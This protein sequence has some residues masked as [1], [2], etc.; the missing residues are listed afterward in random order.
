MQETAIATQV[1]SMTR[2]MLQEIERHLDGKSLSES[3][4]YL[5]EIAHSMGW[6]WVAFN[7]DTSSFVLPTDERGEYL[8][9][10]MGWSGSYLSEWEARRLAQ[11]CPVAEACRQTLLPF[12]WDMDGSDAWS[13]DAL[14]DLQRQALSYYR[15]YAEGGVTVPVHRPEGKTAYISW[16][17]GTRQQARR[18]YDE[19]ADFLFLVSHCYVQWFYRISPPLADSHRLR[20]TVN[21]TL[22]E[23]ECLTWA[24]RGKTEEEIGMILERSAATS[25]F[26]LRNAVVKLNASNRTHAVAK[27]CSMGLISVEN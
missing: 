27:A 19:A 21:L 14:Y 7:P 24:G 10:R 12:Y 9:G 17:A 23:L 8:A 13:M 16:L 4:E 20:A 15:E 18:L 5:S 26:H 11:T 2:P 6:K 25:R 1:N 22:R 3:G